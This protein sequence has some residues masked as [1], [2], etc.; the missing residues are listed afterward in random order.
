MRLPVWL[1]VS[2]PLFISACATSAAYHPQKDCAAGSSSAC[3]DWAEA[4]AR[5]GELAQAETA[6]GKGCEGGIVSSCISQGELL[7]RRGELDAAEQP[8]RK[9][10]LEELPEA[11]EALADLY[12]ARGDAKSLEVAE[13]LRFEALAID[14][15]VTE[16]ITR[17]Q[18]DSRGSPSTAILLN[19]Q[20]MAFLSRR[21]S[22]GGHAAFGERAEFNGFLGYQHHASTWAIPYARIMLGTAG[23]LGFNYGGEVGL[24]LAL[25]PIGHL[26]F[27]VGST[28]A[29]PLHVSAGIGI[30]ALFLLLALVAAR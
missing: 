9:A 26:D 10:Y 15:P 25:G 22:L 18:V 5:Q 30:N 13:E 24:K 28:R 14:K 20:P 17:Y 12:E 19:I 6:F 23:G 1:V 16:F 4:L 11:H 21:L 7:I 3:E 2:M 27:A 8:L 29:M